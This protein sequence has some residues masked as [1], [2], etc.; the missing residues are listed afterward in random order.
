MSEQLT[1]HR[2]VSTWWWLRKRTYFVFVMRE[3]SSLFVAWYVIFLLQLV[4]AVGRSDTAYAQFWD[5]ADS[6]VVVFVNA[7]GFAFI[8]LHAITWF[9]VTPQ[10]M[11]LQV[12]GRP[13]P[14]WLIIGAQY[15]GLAIVSAFIWWLVNR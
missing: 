5:W 8:V 13:V 10:A 7:V 4:K 15:V 1:L 12:R 2:R 9:G 6:P 11:A 3:L 14:A